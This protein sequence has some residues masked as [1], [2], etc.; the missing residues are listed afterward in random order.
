MLRPLAPAKEKLALD[1]A[2][3]LKRIYCADDLQAIYRQRLRYHLSY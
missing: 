3:L 1:E 2:I